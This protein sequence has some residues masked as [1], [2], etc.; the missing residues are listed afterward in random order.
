[1][2]GVRVKIRVG[3]SLRVSLEMTSNVIRQYAEGRK[4]GWPHVLSSNYVTQGLVY[5]AR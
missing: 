1:M 2:L 3:S 4:E 5:S